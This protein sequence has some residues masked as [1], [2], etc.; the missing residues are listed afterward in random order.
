MTS[1]LIILLLLFV[2]FVPSIVAIKRKHRNTVAI[3]L[4]NIAFGWTFLGWFVALIWSVV[5]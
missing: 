1:F 2:Y 3:V 4:T 5:N